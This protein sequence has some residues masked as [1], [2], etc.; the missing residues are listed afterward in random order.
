MS[1]LTKE[2]EK[3]L[4]YEVDLERAREVVEAE[5]DAHE[6]FIK[7]A[8]KEFRENCQ[9][10]DTEMHY[11]GTEDDPHWDENCVDCGEM[12]SED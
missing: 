10:T 8:E 1:E 9:H 4:Q 11:Y 7:E 2:Q 3:E 12:V 5:K 6:M